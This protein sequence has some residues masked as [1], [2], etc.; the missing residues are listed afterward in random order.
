MTGGGFDDEH[1]ENHFVVAF[2]RRE[3][4]GEEM[5]IEIVTTL[6]VSVW[7][8]AEP[9]L[10]TEYIVVCGEMHAGEPMQ[11]TESKPSRSEMT[12]GMISSR[13]VMFSWC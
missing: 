5:H 13:D 8:E 3:S 2:W 11:E 4:Q 1:P 10:V 6:E 7:E 9:I 12:Q